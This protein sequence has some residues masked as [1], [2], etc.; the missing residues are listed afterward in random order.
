L[1]DGLAYK[2]SQAGMSEEESQV[3]E[4][5]RLEGVRLAFETLSW[6]IADRESLA[7]FEV[8]PASVAASRSSSLVTET[9]HV[10]YIWDIPRSYLLCTHLHRSPHPHPRINRR[11]RASHRRK[12]IQLPVGQTLISSPCSPLTSC[13]TT[14]PP[15]PSSHP[16]APRE[17]ATS[18]QSWENPF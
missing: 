13:P 5:Q 10:R 15:S 8:G 18:E 17:M 7:Y 2:P 1:S 16:T 9:D 11:P 12:A 14:I 4:V 3:E 6:A